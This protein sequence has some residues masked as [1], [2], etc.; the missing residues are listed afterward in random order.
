LGRGIPDAGRRGSEHGFGSQSGA[1]WL[2]EGVHGIFGTGFG[3]V[4]AGGR[5]AGQT[6]RA[7]GSIKGE[8]A[9]PAAFTR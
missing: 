7:A 4:R 6:G 1:G 9:S 3:R 8:M 2:A 5:F